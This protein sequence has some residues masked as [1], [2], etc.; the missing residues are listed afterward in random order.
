M[1][2]LLICAEAAWCRWV[3]A[4]MAENRATVVGHI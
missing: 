2:I 4:A 1:G 3:L